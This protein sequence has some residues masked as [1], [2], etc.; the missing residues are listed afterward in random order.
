MAK[1]TVHVILENGISIVSFTMSSENLPAVE[2]E[3]LNDKEKHLMKEGEH[4]YG[5]KYVED[6]GDDASV[7]QVERS[8]KIV[9][10]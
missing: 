4:T 6:G 7:E 3:F 1:C 5:E 10:L 2:N 8:V 9:D